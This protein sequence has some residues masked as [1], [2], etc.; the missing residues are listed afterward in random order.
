MQ[1]QW[2]RKAQ[3]HV[4]KTSMLSA[5]SPE[6]LSDFVSR[7]ET[8][9]RILVTG[10]VSEFE[11]QNYFSQTSKN[12]PR[13]QGQ[14]W[15]PLLLETFKSETFV[16]VR[17]THNVMDTDP[18]QNGQVR[19]PFKTVR[20]THN[21]TERGNRSKSQ[22]RKDSTEDGYRSDETDQAM[23]KSEDALSYPDLT[24]TVLE[25]TQRNH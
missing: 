9:H 11:T 2:E 25:S 1:N 14:L 10:H 22:T 21:S 15:I 4:S 18:A 24:Q 13:G 3:T 6:E 7:L 16:T 12:E 19:E 5:S 20:S 17:P 23:F 8:M